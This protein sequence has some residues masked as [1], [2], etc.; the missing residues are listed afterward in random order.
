MM[1]K[2]Y[3]SL[4]HTHITCPQR[5]PSPNPKRRSPRNP[6]VSRRMEEVL[7]ERL[8]RGI[9]GGRVCLIS[10]YSPFLPPHVSSFHHHSLFPFFSINLSS[11][12][13]PYSS[14]R[15]PIHPPL[16]RP[17]PPF[18][19]PLITFLSSPFPSPNIVLHLLLPPIYS[20]YSPFP[21]FLPASPSP[22]PNPLPPHPHRHGAGACIKAVSLNA[23]GL[24]PRGVQQ[25]WRLCFIDNQG[26][27]T[28]IFM[29]GSD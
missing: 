25:T 24:D 9:Q 21:S 6:T 2:I 27:K 13:F 23:R 10:G 8:K 20:Y 28:R 26:R 15:V 18:L 1:I 29:C 19:F 3:K 22:L 11:S 4:P 14:S 7:H 17:P 5:K 16:P 12:F